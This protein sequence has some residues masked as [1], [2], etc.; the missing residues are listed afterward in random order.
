MGR[1]YRRPRKSMIDVAIRFLRKPSW[2]IWRGWIVAPN[3]GLFLAKSGYIVLLGCCSN[4]IGLSKCGLW[5]VE[6]V[7]WRAIRIGILGDFYSCGVLRGSCSLTITILTSLPTLYVGSIPLACPPPLVSSTLVKI[8]HIFENWSII[9]N[10]SLILLLSLQL[11]I[12]SIILVL[13]F[14]VILHIVI[15]VLSRLGGHCLPSPIAQAKHAFDKHRRD[16]WL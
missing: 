3:A 12:L 16:E 1:I 13:W 9:S 5:Y 14:S 6:L 10:S 15:V 7:V 4:A 2:D 8:Q 11:H